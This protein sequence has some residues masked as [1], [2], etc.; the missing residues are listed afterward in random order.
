MAGPIWFLNWGLSAFGPVEDEKDR[1]LKKAN[2]HRIPHSERFESGRKR[3]DFWLKIWSDSHDSLQGS[4][5]TSD[6]YADELRVI[7]A[8]GRKSAMLLFWR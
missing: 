3:D 7:W 5:K 2:R 6:G 4:S 8:L 1:K